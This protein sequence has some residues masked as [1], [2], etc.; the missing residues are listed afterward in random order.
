MAKKA[1]ASGQARTKYQQGI[2]RRYYEHRDTLMLQKLGDLVGDLYLAEGKARDRLW[3]RVATALKNL[4]VPPDRIQH[5]IESDN[6]TYLANLL[7]E[8]QGGGGKT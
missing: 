8:L 2:I 1:S 4:S 6:P 7:Q 5:L 3:V